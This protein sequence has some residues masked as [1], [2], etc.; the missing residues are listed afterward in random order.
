MN[1]R[2]N[3]SATLLMRPADSPHRAALRSFVAALALHDALSEV[4]GRPE[5]FALK[6]PNDVLLNDGKVA[7]ILLESFD[8]G[9][10]EVQ[11]AIGIGVNLIAAPG[12]GELE[13]GAV[14]PVSLLGECGISV[15]AAEFLYPLAAAYALHEDR[16]VAHGFEPIRRLWL[17][18]AT[19]RGERITARIGATEYRGRFA[20][21]DKDG[22]LVLETQDGRKAIPAADV[23]F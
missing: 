20:D 1:P 6:W 23:F 17:E 10:G 18:R 22:Q 19:R 13:P 16:F 4:S 8:L 3:F 5:L 14:R 7:G 15:D 21:V 9:G 12:A 2:G 11:L